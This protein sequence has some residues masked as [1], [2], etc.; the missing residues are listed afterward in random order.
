VK[1]QRAINHPSLTHVF[2]RYPVL[3]PTTKLRKQRADA[4]ARD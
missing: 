4:S 3:C 2:R 1:Y